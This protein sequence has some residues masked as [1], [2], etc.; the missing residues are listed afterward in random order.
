MKS[1]KKSGNVLIL[2]GIFL[3]IAALILTLYNWNEANK[4]DKASSE[5]M[6][7]L[8][9]EID[10]SDDGLDDKDSVPDDRDMPTLDVDGNLYIGYISIPSIGLELP[11]M[12]DWDY[13]KLRISPCR[14]SGSVY[15]DDLVIA[16][17]NYRNHFSALRYQEPGTEVLFTDV[18]GN[19]FHYEIAD[20]E[21][22]E[23]TQVED[24]IDSS[25]N[26]DLTLFT[27]TIGG[28]TRF[29]VRCVRTDQ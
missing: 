29:T 28:R 21:T 25:D 16:G 22:L 18:E 8:L 15:T 1:R 7:Q 9:D 13:D 27:C 20:L 10:D 6:T 2:I 19:V 26:W 24:M 5:V 11:V 4:A 14:Y 23:P 3:L 12:Q 17:H